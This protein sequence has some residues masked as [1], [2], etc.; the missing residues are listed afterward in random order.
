MFL[1]IGI[2]DSDDI[3]LNTFHI[4]YLKK[5]ECSIRIVM[6]NSDYYH[7]SYANNKKRDEDFESLLLKLNSNEN[8]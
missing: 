5:F 7:I 2:G 1:N 4:I 6:K 8:E 3:I